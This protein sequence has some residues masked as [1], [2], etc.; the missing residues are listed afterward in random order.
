MIETEANKVWVPLS[1]RQ[2]LSLGRICAIASCNLV[3]GL[4]YNIISALFEPFIKNLGINMTIKTILLFYASFIGFLIAPILGVI[5][6]GLTY[7]YGRRRIFVISG[8]IFVVI[9]LLL[10]MYCYEIGTFLKPSHPQ[11]YRKL[12]FIIAYV[13]A[14]AAGNI[15]QSPARV[16]CSDV[17]PLTQQTLMSNICQVY[18]GVSSIFPNLLGGFEVYKYTG[19]KQEQ[20]LLV[21]CLSIAFVAMMISVISAREE[22]L[23]VKPPKVNPFKKIWVAV[24]KMPKPF[25]RCVPSFCLSFVAI[26]QY[27]I[28]FTDFMGAE[29]MHGNNSDDA[30]SEMKK[31]YQ[32]GV[33]WAMMCNSVN[34]VTQLIYGFLNNK[35]CEIIGM[36]WAMVIGGILISVSLLLFLF[37]KNKYAFLGLTGLIGLGNVIY[38]AIPYA[39]VSIVIPTEELGNNLGILNCF[40]VIG[41]QL[42][43]FIIGSGVG[44]LVNNSSGKKIGFSA[45]F[46]FLTTIASFWVVEPTLGEAGQYQSMNDNPT[47]FTY[48]SEINN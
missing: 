2:K 40:C 1:K 14:F 25:V 26:Y 43:N 23:L 16:L 41:Q 20:F 45:I 32:K 38:M 13:I 46:G 7:K 18:G 10:M 35:V 30:S 24:K 31:L 29:I 44:R 6:D 27:G 15:V 3:P 9:S 8:S 12:V 19:L 33:S 5:S 21:V 22:P 37:I 17:T 39:I 28:A 34:N 48:I 36:K 42:S 4:L 11:P 47:D